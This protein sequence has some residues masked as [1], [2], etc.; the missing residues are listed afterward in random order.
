MWPYI[1]N[2]SVITSVKDT[3]FHEFHER[4]KTSLIV[5]SFNCR[6]DFVEHVEG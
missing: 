1:H 5:S 3:V 2:M 4:N 6:V